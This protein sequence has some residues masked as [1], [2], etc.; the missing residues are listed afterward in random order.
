MRTKIL[1]IIIFI[2]HCLYSNAQKYWIDS[3]YRDSIFP[4]EVYYVSYDYR[5]N[6][7]NNLDECINKAVT[8]VQSMLANSISSIVTSKACGATEIINQN[9][10]LDESEI[11]TN[12]F[13]IASSAHLV[14]VNLEHFYDK[15]SNIVHAIAYVKKQDLVDYCEN[16]LKQGLSSLNE[17]LNSIHEFT[18]KGLKS[19]ANELVEVCLEDIK[20][21]PLLIS[22]LISIGDSSTSAVDYT[23]TYE[24]IYK[25]LIQ[26][27]STLDHNIS[28]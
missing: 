11:F 22:Q 26:Q 14:N 1:L 19:E 21:F 9:G 13:S 18:E 7:N 10:K 16:R 28:I 25:R 17:K 6:E 5:I 8:G 23:D 15:S 4:K 2:T 3:S 20:I 27:K 12:D 24:Q